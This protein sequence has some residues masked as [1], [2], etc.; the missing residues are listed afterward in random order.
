MYTPLRS[1][2]HMLL[3]TFA[4]PLNL[5][6]ATEVWHYCGPIVLFTSCGH[7]PPRHGAE[8]MFLKLT[9]T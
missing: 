8:D 4:A 5:M 1:T 6:Y 7:L 9:V 2:A 3:Y